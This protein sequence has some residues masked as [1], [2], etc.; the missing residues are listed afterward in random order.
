MK[1]RMMIGAAA[2]VLIVLGSGVFYS[3]YYRKESIERLLSFNYW[4]ARLQGKDLYDPRGV[5]WHGNRNLREIALTFDDGPK[6][7][8]TEQALD[9]L[10]AAGVHATFSLVGIHIKKE[11]DLVKRELAE[12]N[13]IVCHS[14]DHQDMRHLDVKHVYSEIWDSR[15]LL[16]PLGGRFVGFRPPW[17]KLT[18]A[19]IEGSQQNHLPVIMYSIASDCFVGQDPK[20][21]AERIPGHVENGTILLMHDT[22][23]E[24][25]AGLPLVLSELKGEGYTFVTISEMLAHL[26]PEDRPGR[27][28]R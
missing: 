18:D 21:W 8:T 26:P 25:V 3:H 16:D 13:E 6:S 28:S 12:G 1:Q 27:L 15:I 24:T 9:A 22:Y 2:L 7:P 17:A 20:R 14:Y 4:W 10:K 5:L 23:P 11:P 19:G